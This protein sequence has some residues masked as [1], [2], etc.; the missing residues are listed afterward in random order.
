[1]KKKTNDEIIAQTN[2]L[3]EDLDRSYYLEAVKYLREKPLFA[4]KWLGLTDT[5][6]VIWRKTLLGEICLNLE[7][8]SK[9]FLFNDVILLKLRTFR[10]NRKSRVC[11]VTLKHYN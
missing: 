4:L 9:M 6:A 5:P 2:V 7:Y 10:K 11:W 1:M 3:F 8:E